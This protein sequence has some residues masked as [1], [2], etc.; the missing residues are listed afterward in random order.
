MTRKYKSEIALIRNTLKMQTSAEIQDEILRN[1]LEIIF[2]QGAIEGL[3][4]AMNEVL[5]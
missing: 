3:Q 5:L 1:T 2:Q 4:T